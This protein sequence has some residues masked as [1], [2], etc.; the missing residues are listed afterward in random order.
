M[1]RGGRSS[2]CGSGIQLP[3]DENPSAPIPASRPCWR[4]MR[5]TCSGNESLS[6]FQA[7][8]TFLVTTPPRCWLAKG[9][10]ATHLGW[11]VSVSPCRLRRGGEEPGQNRPRETSLVA[12]VP[13]H[14][15]HPGSHRTLPIFPGG[16]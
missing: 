7:A 12:G 2:W 3:P 10:R 1:T 14:G 16:P 15:S 4:G 5:R 9:G 13:D 8:V 11:P 6:L